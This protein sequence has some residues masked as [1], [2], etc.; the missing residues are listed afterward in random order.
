MP[1][2]ILTLKN[3]TFFRYTS[4]IRNITAQ[5]GVT[6]KVTEYACYAL[7]LIE[8][9]ADNG[10]VTAEYGYYTDGSI[11]SPKNDTLYAE[12]VLETDENLTDLR[13]V[14]DTEMLT[15]NHYTYAPNGNSIEKHQIGETTRYIYNALEQITI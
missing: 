1:G 3:S 2:D 10:T 6:E 14:L 12:Y 4:L 13:T 15:D 8:K 9:V 7:D 11:R 5:R